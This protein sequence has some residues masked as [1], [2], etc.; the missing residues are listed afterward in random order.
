MTGQLVEPPGGTREETGDDVAGLGRVDDTVRGEA[1][2][3]AEGAAVGTELLE[4]LVLGRSFLGPRGEQLRRAAVAHPPNS[5]VGH[6]RCASGSK[7][8]EPITKYPWP[9]ALRST[10]VMSGIV[11]FD[12]ATIGRAWWRITPSA[13]ASGP[14]MNPGVS[15]R[16]T[17]GIAKQSHNRMK[18]VILSAAALSIA[19]ARTR[20]WLPM[21]PTVRP[22]TRPNEVTMFC[23]NAGRSSKVESMSAIS[24]IA[25]RMS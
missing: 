21:K 8:R 18:R 3:H 11:A 1:L 14:I 5:A 13:S 16:K 25:L 22:C 17:S 6:M 20:D 10:N 23:A 12:N 2:G 24:S 7:P 19:P 4:R 9:N 15:T